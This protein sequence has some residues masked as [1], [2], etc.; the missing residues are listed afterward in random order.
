MLITLSI[1]VEKKKNAYS[2]TGTYRSFGELLE[3]IR[4]FLSYHFDWDE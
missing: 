4:D 2:L 3:A 1:V